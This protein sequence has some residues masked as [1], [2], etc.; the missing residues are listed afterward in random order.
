MAK[1]KKFKLYSKLNVNVIDHPKI[2]FGRLK[3]KKMASFKKNR[4]ETIVRLWFNF[5]KKTIITGLLWKF[6]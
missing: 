3:K 5:T 1:V 4:K 6:M 2:R